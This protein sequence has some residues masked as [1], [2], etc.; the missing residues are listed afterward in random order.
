MG[1]DDEVDGFHFEPPGD[2]SFLLTVVAARAV[3]R[4]WRIKPKAGVLRLY[5]RLGTGR[6]LAPGKALKVTRALLDDRC[7]LVKIDGA[8]GPG[9]HTDVDLSV[10]LA[11]YVMDVTV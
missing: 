11:P 7:D 10:A 5:L 3:P 1:V 6:A 2:R 8:A 9:V 4:G